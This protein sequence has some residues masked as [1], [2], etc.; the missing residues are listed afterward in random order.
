LAA[1]IAGC[2][3]A[4]AAARV[5]HYSGVRVAVPDSWPVYKLAA[6]PTTCVRFNRHALYLGTP[7]PRQRCPAHAVG[8][9]EAILVAPRTAQLAA[10]RTDAA[11]PVTGA[12]AQSPGGSEAE[13]QL[14]RAVVTATWLRHRDV[15]ARALGHHKLPLG[16]G[17]TTSAPAARAQTAVRANAA[18]VSGGVYKGLGFDPCSAPS[19]SQ[20]SAWHSSPYHAIGVY[21]GGANMGCSQPA[22]T[23]SWVSHEA[24]AGWHFIPTYVGLQAPSNSCGCAAISP[25]LASSEGKAAAVDAIQ[26]AQSLGLSAGSPIYFDMEAYSTGG[27]SSGAVL[28][29]LSAWTSR[30]HQ[31][32]YVS[33]VY[34]S[35]G[36]GIRDLV[37]RYGT[38]YLE[39]NDIWIADWNGL[40]TTSDP[41]VP[42]GDWAS[43]QRL[44]QYSGGHNETY[45]GVTLNID[46]D[47]L[48][49][50]T[51]GTPVTVAASPSLGVNPLVSGAVRLHAR[52]AGNT[53]VTA[54]QVLA[55]ESAKSL[56]P[57][58]TPFQSGADATLIVHSQLPYFAVQALNSTGHTIGTTKTVSTRPH[59]SIF[60]RSAFVPARGLAGVPVG[61]FLGTS[62]TL[63]AT[64]LSGTTVIGNGRA[65]AVASEDGGI[66]YF[67][68]TPM[69]RSLLAGTHGRHLPV[70]VQLRDAT[71]VTATA[72]L[73]LV[74]YSTQPP[75]PP[76]SLSPAPTLRLVGATD[77]VYHDTS[78]GILA[79][80]SGSVPC[81]VRTTITSAG[82]TI[83]QSGRQFLGAHEFGYLRF[84]LT[85]QGQTMLQQASGNQLAATVTLKD[86]VATASGQIGLVSY[87]G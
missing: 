75:R 20:M 74:P 59:L 60:G 4:P 44:H 67:R 15:V 80:C 43:A 12:T 68:L 81:R 84:R 77:F 82:V 41:Y 86:G 40:Q 13:V 29:F 49:G 51:A 2:V 24:G 83:A 56:A 39:P 63:T 14:G 3:A 7:S 58:G 66:A 5:V 79:T 62:C 25:S 21:I 31:G 34:S 47:Y 11:L 76:H 6:R 45:G 85:P 65:T 22:L 46:G 30:L 50:S 61:C 54:W 17:D 16:A 10:D 28:T 37:S 23:P 53:K 71:G 8:R 35:G 72:P 42:S 70:V 69:G 78:G 36:S 87:G 9:T 48:N 73:F 57:L 27:Q 26:H 55:G 64:I 19:T 38:S 32:G 18:A 33:G 1:V 52:W